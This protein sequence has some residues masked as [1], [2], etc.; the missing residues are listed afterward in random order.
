MVQPTQFVYKPP[1]HKGLAVVYV[2]D[3]LL[4]VCKPSG[5]LSVPGRGA[6][7][8]DCLYSRVVAE[9]PT[10][11]VVH[12]LDMATSGLVIFALSKAVQSACSKMFAARSIGKT[13]LAWVDGK[14]GNPVGE[15]NLPLITDWPNRPKQKIDVEQGKPALTRYALQFYDVANAMS[16]LQLT[17]V[18]GRSHQLRVHMQALGHAIVGDQFYGGRT[19]RQML[20]HAHSLAFNH[21]VTMAPLHIQCS[22]QLLAKSGF[23]Y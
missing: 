1:V 12:R 2:D 6:A 4:V 22:K 20:L 17:P 10:A 9:Y 3:H 19:H 7:H 16:L 13:Y 11:L 5:L 15:I 21:P 18:T 8:Q 14:L 23:Y